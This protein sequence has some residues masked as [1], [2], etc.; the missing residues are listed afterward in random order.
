MR[1]KNKKRLR[2]LLKLAGETIFVT[3]LAAVVEFLLKLIF[4]L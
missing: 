4:G 2:K 1:R 3:V